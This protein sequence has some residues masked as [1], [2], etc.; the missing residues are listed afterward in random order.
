[1]KTFLPI[2]L[3]VLVP[4]TLLYSQDTLKVPSEYSTIQGAINSSVNGDLVLIDEGVYYENINFTGKHITVASE[5]IID[6]N[7]SHIDNTIINGS[8][9]AVP[10]FA[11]VVFFSGGEDTTSVLTGLTLTGGKG[12]Y[13]S[14]SRGGG[15][16]LMLAGGKICNNKIINNSVIIPGGTAGGGGIYAS[17]VEPNK[18]I[19]RDNI[20]SGNLLDA[21]SCAGAGIYYY[22]QTQN[23]ILNNEI[24]NNICDGDQFA[25]GGGIYCLTDLASSINFSIKGNIFSGNSVTTDLNS[26]SE[27]GGIFFDGNKSEFRNNLVTGNSAGFGGGISIFNI[28]SDEDFTLHL[29]KVRSMKKLMRNNSAAPVYNPSQFPVDYTFINNTF[30]NNTAFNSGGAVQSTGIPVT[31]VNSIIWNNDAPLDP[32]ISGTLTIEHSDIQGGWNGTGN[33]NVDPLFADTVD[34]YLTPGSSPCI[35][36]GNPETIFNDPED[37]AH[38]GYAL[39]PSLGSVRSD[40]GAYGGNPETTISNLFVHTPLFGEFLARILSAPYQ[41]KQAIADSFV[42]SVSS[43]PYI[44]ENTAYYI[45][46]GTASSI[47]ASGD[48]NGWDPAA[49]PM[50]K[51]EG[52]NFWYRGQVFEPDARLDYKFVLN[53]SSWILDPR[54]PRQVTGGYGPNSELPMPAYVYPPEIQYYPSIQHGTLHDTTFY[55]TNLNNSR[56]IRV[57]TPPGYPAPGVSYPVIVFHD[58]LEYTTLGFAPNILDYL[59]SENKINPVIGIFV[60]PVN[61]NEEYA[62]SQR[63]QFTSFIVDELMPYIDNRYNVSTDP[64]FRAMIGFSFGGH[65][66]T[67]ICYN[68]PEEFGLCAPLSPAYWPNNREVLVQCN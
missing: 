66:S 29:A 56:T 16:I 42:N 9:P 60:P 10:D 2:F 50:T 64:A 23:G 11:S 55:S 38:P 12:T 33:I 58:G 67:Q 40:M 20:I 5:F 24:T 31:F 41:D 13:D 47:N 59:I 35:D 68:H 37:P 21:E 8:Q 51:I 18:L 52:T 49:F 43:F 32:Q 3:I 46:T 57:Y 30:V 28:T 14:G 1:M 63:E 17:I 34:F 45:Y 6:G 62:F 48:A 27:G 4:T 61:R 36:A 54:N 15:G 39:L 53:G 7:I 25:V 22:S 65:I 26:F 44:E 19:L